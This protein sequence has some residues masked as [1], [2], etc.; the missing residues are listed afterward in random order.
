MSPPDLPGLP[1]DVAGAPI[2]PSPWA[3]RAF[4]LAVGLSERGVFGWPDF[5]AAL[6]EARAADPDGDYFAAWLGALESVLA[7][8]GIA[9]PEAVADMAEAWHRAARA[10]PHGQPIRAPTSLP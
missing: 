8:R 2:F 1:R 10:T 7:R 3:A 6:A 9:G 4:A 5:S